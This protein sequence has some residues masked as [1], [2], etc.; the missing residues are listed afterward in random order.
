MREGFFIEDNTMKKIEVIL[1]DWVEETRNIYVFAGA[2]LIAIKELND[3]ELRVKTN[4][5]NMCGKC[6]MNVPD[7]WEYGVKDGNCQHLIQDVDKYVCS[8]GSN[9]PFMCCASD[10]SEKDFCCITW[11]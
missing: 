11:R 10:D 8:L 7:D 9:R 4:G 6:C 3:S 1:P 5:C 2:E